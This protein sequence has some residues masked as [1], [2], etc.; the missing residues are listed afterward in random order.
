MDHQVPKR[1]RR[2]SHSSRSPDRGN[3]LELELY[4]PSTDPAAAGHGLAA[5]GSPAYGATV[6]IATPQGTQIGQLDGGGGHVGFRSF[7]VHFGLGSYSGPVSVH[8]Q[9][10]ETDGTLRQQ[11]LSL[12]PGV[13]D[14]MLAATAQ[15]VSR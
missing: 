11:T 8:V 7:D 3:A 9:W 5:I 12:T 2:C 4:R 15:E 6:T 1:R 13:H 14:L 10:R